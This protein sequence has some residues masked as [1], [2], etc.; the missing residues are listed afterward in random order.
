MTR[1]CRTCSKVL[2]EKQRGR[3]C[4]IKCSSNDPDVKAR[5]RATAIA[6]HGPAGHD[7]EKRKT[8]L[9]KRY[10]KTSFFGDPEVI[11]KSRATLIARYGV[12]HAGTINRF[13]IDSDVLTR[14]YQVEGLTCD[15]IARRHGVT[16]NCIERKMRLHGVEF[17]KNSVQSKQER[18]LHALLTENGVSFDVNT[19][20]VITPKELDIYVPSARLAIEIHGEYW[21]SEM[22]SI[23]KMLHRQKYESCSA[24][25]IHLFQFFASEL[26][27]K[28]TIVESMVLTKLGFSEKVGARALAIRELN[29]NEYETFMIKNHIQGSVRAPVRIGLVDGSN[30]IVAAMSFGKSRFDKNVEWELLRSAARTGVRVIGGAE[31]IYKRFLEM[32]MPDSVVSYC[33]RRFFSGA[34]Y[35]KLGFEHVRDT[36]PSYYYVHDTDKNRLHTRFA[37]QKHKMSNFLEK[38]D[39]SL[40]EVENAHANGYYR[41]W[42]AG[43]GVFHWNNR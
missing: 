42:D 23:D 14:E 26:T 33:D 43:H 16:R 20:R 29:F 41:I 8:T 4:S 15:E 39:P 24:V 35:S 10:G 34:V 36:A 31:R 17:R 30:E 6:R 27:S 2:A 5:K 11:A 21:H 38:F 7:V 19:R 12:E 37:F 40:T 9:K 13:D 25:G 18:T 32:C 3:Y 1:R 22:R 28:R